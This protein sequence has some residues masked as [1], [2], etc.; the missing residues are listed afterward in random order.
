[1]ISIQLFS[2]IFSVSEKLTDIKQTQ[3]A[4]NFPCP[5]TGENA[6][7]NANFALFFFC[8]EGYL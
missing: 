3:Y 6:L 8:R 2:C 4:S 1:M 7:Q 5:L